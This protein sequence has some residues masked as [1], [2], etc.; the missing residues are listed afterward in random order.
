MNLT[1]SRPIKIA[2]GAGIPLILAGLAFTM[3]APKMS[4]SAP[5]PVVVHHP[6]VTHHPAARHA[7]HAAAPIVDQSLPAALRRA[8][9]HHG[10]VVAV[11]YAPDD[12]SALGPARKGAHAA[13]AGFAVLNIRNENIARALAAKLPGATDP[14]VIVVRRPGRVA[15]QL[16][17]YSD[18]ETVAQAALNSRK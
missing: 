14:S 12:A 18:A 15:V 9:A 6:A 2:A 11:L 3:L 10:V 17:G 1:L 13:H 8:L 16:P 5:I 7:R 4:G